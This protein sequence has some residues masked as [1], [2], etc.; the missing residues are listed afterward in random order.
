[1]I[2]KISII[3]FLLVTFNNSVYSNEEDCSNF[4]KLSVDYIK[5]K[6]N[7]IKKKTLSASK[8]FVEDTK[9]FQKK[10]WSDEKKKINNIK[11]KV[12]GE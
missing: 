4:K 9:E 6:S 12:L 5:C 8:N 7:L 10:E 2:K 1:M 11:K 3:I